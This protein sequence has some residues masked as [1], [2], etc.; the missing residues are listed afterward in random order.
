MIDPGYTKQT[1][2][3]QYFIGTAADA[4]TRLLRASEGN[5]N[6]VI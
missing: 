2:Y 6:F 5:N 4:S 1:V 3:G